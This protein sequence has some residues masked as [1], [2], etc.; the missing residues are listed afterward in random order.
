MKQ[1]D[2]DKIKAM[3]NDRIAYNL[4]ERNRTMKK[5][6][7]KKAIFSIA[8]CVLILG[9][10]GTVDAAT[11]GKISNTVKNTIK[12]IFTDENNQEREITGEQYVDENGD[13]WIKYKHET[14]QSSQ[15]IDINKSELEKD[16]LE[17]DANIKNSDGETTTEI[18]IQDK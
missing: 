14:D 12:V 18:T 1:I 10:I 5:M 9:G 15:E 11:D 3:V 16:G 4:Y 6:K 7:L 13:I 2:T 8:V 17:T